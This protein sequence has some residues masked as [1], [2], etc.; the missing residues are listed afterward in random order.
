MV[1]E[2]YGQQTS[3]L[4][5]PVYETMSVKPLGIFSLRDKSEHSQRRRL[6]SHAFSQSNLFDCEPLIAQQIQKLM[7][8]VERSLGKP[9][10]MLLMFRLTAFDIVGELC[11]GRLTNILR[12]NA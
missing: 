8:Q 12:T 7:N 11:P 6:L 3:F 4:K 9:L 2:L 1:K 10:N 5:A